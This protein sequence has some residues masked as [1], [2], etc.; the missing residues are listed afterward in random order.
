[1]ADLY[2]NYAALAAAETEGVD[3]TR[4]VTLFPGAKGASI[5]IHGG[6]IEAGSGEVAAAVAAGAMNCYVFAGIKSSG[7]TD[8]HITSTN[9][10]EPQALA[11]VAASTRTLSFH[12]YSGATPVT[13]IGGLDTVRVTRITEALELAGFTVV[14]TS[15]EIAGTDPDNI[16]NKNLNGAGVQ[17][18]MT[19]AQRQAFFPGGNTSRAVRESGA[20]TE[21]FWAYVAA[22]RAGYAGLKVG[23]TLD[24]SDITSWEPRLMGNGLVWIGPNSDGMPPSWQDPRFLY[25]QRV[26]ATPVLGMQIDGASA[27][28]PALIQHLSNMPAW[29]DTLYVTDHADP[30]ADYQGN[31]TSFIENFRD[32]YT[33]VIQQLPTVIRVKVKAGPVLNW[34][35]TTDPALGNGVFSR[36]DPGLVYSDF[37]G[38]NLLLPAEEAGTTHAATAYPTAASSLAGF[39]NYRLSVADDRPRLLPKIGAVGLPFD[40]D[41]LAR[42]A[43]LLG[44]MDEITSWSFTAQGWTMVGFSWFN[45]TG[46]GPALSDLGSARYYRLDVRQAGLN[47][48]ST[49]PDDIPAPVYA[50]NEIIIEASDDP[51]QVQ[52]T[53]PPEFPNP[54]V[55]PTTVELP[56]GGMPLDGPAAARL[57]AA[58][59]TILITDKN[60]VVQ[61]DPIDEWKTLQASIRW[62]E[63]SSGQITVPAHQYIRQQLGAGNRVVIIRRVLGTQ[64]I[65]VAGPIEKVMRERS[66]AGENGGVGMLTISFVEDM[67]WLGARLAYPNPALPIDGQVTDYWT[68]DGDPEMAMLTLVNTQ[69]G[70]GALTE[71]QIPKLR[72]AAYSGLAGTGTVLLGPTSDVAPRER[73]EKLT[74]VLRKISILGANPPGSSVHHPDSLGFR[75]RQTQIAGENVILFE[76]VRSQDR[77][78]QI[79]FSFSRG[80]LEYYS[81]EQEAPQTTTLMVGGQG[82]GADRALRQFETPDAEQ[83]AWGRFEGYLSRP[84]TD[85]ALVAQADATEDLADKGMTSR[86]ALN[87]S[88]TVDQRYGVHYNAGDIGSVE[89]DADEYEIAP[90]QTVNVQAWPTAGEVVGV[91]I[92]DQSARQDS[93]WGKRMSNLEKRLGR[94]E[95]L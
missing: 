62:K 39:K 75:T 27:R 18:E 58:D 84:G 48:R 80:N 33:N 78:G 88:D 38:M 37:Y 28:Y 46:S 1:V 81:F 2:A 59:Y 17:L 30:E 61:G 22:V 26:G 5:A 29:I 43:W 12:G 4:A 92:G 47:I 40:T 34:Q 52:P 50:M 57:L 65:L 49:Y 23:V 13:A 11:L 45:G 42:S 21:T 36:F 89:M 32:W 63:P 41:G 3:Y 86:L 70:P 6:G 8:L 64:H 73:L 77:R 91:T 79:H 66:D 74:D 94:Q 93:A 67:A 7:N 54:D 53:E 55:P 51:D 24:R 60:L 85:S 9:F 44:V 83:L 87:A 10:D 72:V 69:A 14:P 19:L 35:W 76:P 68:F 16:C 82:E 15:S 31:H 25:C 90:I 95:R 71:R 20:R 56:P